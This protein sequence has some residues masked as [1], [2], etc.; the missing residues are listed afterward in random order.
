M[1]QFMKYFS[2]VADD[3]TDATSTTM[4]MTITTTTT[5]SNGGTTF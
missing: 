3:P 5:P 2:Y 4:A 1:K